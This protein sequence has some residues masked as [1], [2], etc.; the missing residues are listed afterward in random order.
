MPRRPILIVDDDIDHAIIL[1]TVLASVAPD[2]PT[3][4]CTDPG[5]MPDVLYE[6][7]EGSVVLMDRLLRGVESFRH[8][9]EVRRR[10]ADLHVVVLSA[11]LTDEDRERAIRFG[12]ADAVEKP[13]SIAAWKQML[14]RVLGDAE[15]GSDAGTPAQAG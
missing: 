2:A 11:A 10:R 15:G 4:T 5:R 12:A 1:R 8:L 6:A 13:G 3:E 7:A 9:P 14:A